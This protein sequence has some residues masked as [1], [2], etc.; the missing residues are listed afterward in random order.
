[1]VLEAFN[2]ASGPKVALPVG[3]DEST[4]TTYPDRSCRSQG[5]SPRQFAKRTFQDTES[6]MRA[7]KVRRAKTSQGIHRQILLYASERGRLFAVFGGP[8]SC[9]S[10]SKMLRLAEAYEQIT[11]VQ[12]AV[13]Q[14]YPHS[15]S[16]HRILANRHDER[17]R[18]CDWLGASARDRHGITGGVGQNREVLTNFPGNGTTYRHLP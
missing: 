3:S 12:S 16:I 15:H 17:G 11:P 18:A 14:R 7:Q 13:K 8:R 1:M 9:Y 2:N 10:Y 6:E 5:S 4:E